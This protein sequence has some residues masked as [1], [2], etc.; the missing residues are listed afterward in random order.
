MQRRRQHRVFQSSHCAPQVFKGFSGCFREHSLYENAS[1]LLYEKQPETF[2][3]HQEIGF[4][5]DSRFASGYVASRQL[6]KTAFKILVHNAR[7]FMY[8]ALKLR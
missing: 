7:I 1:D 8:P 2:V 4:I 3:T 6:A 5:C